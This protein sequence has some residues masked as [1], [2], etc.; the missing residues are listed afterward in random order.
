[1]GVLRTRAAPPSPRSH[2]ALR[3]C[4]KGNSCTRCLG[5]WSLPL[6]AEAGTRQ[7]QILAYLAS[8]GREASTQNTGG[9]RA[10]MFAQTYINNKTFPLHWL[11]PTEAPDTFCTHLRTGMASICRIPT[12]CS[13][14][15]GARPRPCSFTLKQ[16]LLGP[17]TE[18]E[19]GSEKLGN[20]AN[21]T[22]PGVGR[23]K[24]G[25]LGTALAASPESS[26]LPSLSPLSDCSTAKARQVPSQ[27]PGPWPELSPL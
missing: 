7:S 1:M 14:S 6:A 4:S 27:W 16:P 26:D 20:L 3:G 19:T 17:F 24:P 8:R 12:M 13:Y 21:V 5:A 22:R 9:Q 2:E 15:V 11:P 23:L 10:C 18:E 25:L